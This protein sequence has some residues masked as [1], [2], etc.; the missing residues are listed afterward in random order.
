MVENAKPKDRS[1]LRRRGTA[2]GERVENVE[3]F[4]DLV[5]VFAV[6]RLSHALLE[7][8]SAAGALRVSLLIVAV[9][10]VWIYTSWV[11][12]WL[13]PERLPVRLCLFAL[14]GAGLL[15]SVSIPHAF[16]DNAMVFAASYVAMQM[17]RTLFFL[18]AGRDSTPAVRRGF[19][20]ILAWFV[21]SSLFWVG[22]ALR[23]D[24]Q[25]P[26]WSI[27]LGV[28][29]A[30]PLVYYWTPGLGRSHTQDWNIA[31]GHL[32]ER[33]GL[34]VIIALGESLLM[35]GTAFAELPWTADA[36]I[37]LASAAVG[38]ILMWWIYFDM[39]AGRAHHRIAHSEDPGRQGR[40][41]YT[42]LHVFI[43]A[44][45]IVCAVADEIVL[46]SVGHG[47]ADGH[48]E[49]HNSWMVILAGPLIYI[50]G[51]ALFKWVMNDRRAPPFSHLAGC[52]LLLA[53]LAPAH[54]GA[55]STLA[56]G[57]AT[58]AVLLVVAVWESIALRRS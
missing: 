39:G 9:W 13:A 12:N 49:T 42:Y 20:R 57:V 53:L 36:L 19:Q 54:G 47:A 5:F 1:L 51:T 11:T 56:L 37:A 40:L 2:E 43:V 55:W 24:L 23:H 46:G 14:M 4:F 28:E 15:L 33:C 52:V 35:T 22:G 16:H 7:D 38:S 17:G 58:T 25:L 10:W 26:A 34:F 45:I 32:A 44:G 6:T 21:V 50:T 31:G 3:L 18:W 41:A 29:L 27:A 48:R 30:G 8:L